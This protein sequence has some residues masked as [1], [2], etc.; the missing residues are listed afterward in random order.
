[1]DLAR[2]GRPQRVFNRPTA[3]G[4]SAWA[5]SRHNYFG[6]IGAHKPVSPARQPDLYAGLDGIFVSRSGLM[7]ATCRSKRRE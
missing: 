4:P 6:P 3:P 7:L 2:Q 5:H 1:M